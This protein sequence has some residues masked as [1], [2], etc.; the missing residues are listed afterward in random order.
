MLS[1]QL[2]RTSPESV[3]SSDKGQ[4]SCHLVRTGSA[5][6]FPNRRDCSALNWSESVLSPN[7][8]V[9]GTAQQ[10]TCQNRSCLRISKQ[11]RLLRSQLVRTSPESV[12]FSDKGQP[13]SQL[14]RTGPACVFPNRRDCSG[15]NWS[16]PVLSPY[17]LVIWDSPA[18]NLSE[19]VL[20]SYFQTEEIAQVSTGQ[21]QS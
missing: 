10:S 21:N 4:P 11:K 7:S 2:V 19:P 3:F 15:L 5:F 14:V 9:K 16:E 17:S 13:S 18:V 1:S 8:L 6:V 20:P 12:F